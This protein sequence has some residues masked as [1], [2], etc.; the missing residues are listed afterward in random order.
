[1][2]SNDD[3]S[4]L[5]YT[6]EDDIE[7]FEGELPERYAIAWRAQLAGFLE[8]GEISSSLYDELVE[9]VPAVPDD[10]S[11]DVAGAM[12][13]C[14]PRIAEHPGTTS[15]ALLSEL[16]MRV[17]RDIDRFAGHM[18][19]RV[20]IAWDAYLW[21]LPGSPKVIRSEDYDELIELIPPIPNDPVAELFAERDD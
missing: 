11:V 17:Q 4:W 8:A 18:P 5:R 3:P 2:T 14:A 16:K 21:T 13:E 7:H 20:A 15:D 6:L 10:P 12:H 1:M 19:E 9:R